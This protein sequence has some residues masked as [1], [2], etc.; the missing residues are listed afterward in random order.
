ML[1]YLDGG[2]PCYEF[3]AYLCLAAGV[4]ML[5]ASMLSGWFTWKARYK[6]LRGKI[7]IRK[8][9]ISLVMLAVSVVVLIWRAAFPATLQTVW[10]RLYFGG[11][12]FLLAGA[13]AEGYYGGRLNHR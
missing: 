9:R 2:K 10:L 12:V 4:L 13:A 6:G 1:L 8:I 7:F 11:I 3:I 5:A